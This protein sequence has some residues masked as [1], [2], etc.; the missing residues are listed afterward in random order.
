[1]IISLKGDN[2]LLR[3]PLSF[4]IIIAIVVVVIFIIVIFSPSQRGRRYLIMHF[5]FQSIGV[6]APQARVS[7]S[8]SEEQGRDGGPDLGRPWQNTAVFG[9]VSPSIA[10]EGQRSRVE[11]HFQQLAA[12]HCGTEGGEIPRGWGSTWLCPAAG[13]S[14]MPRY[15]AP[16]S[17]TAAELR[18]PCKPPSKWGSISPL[19]HHPL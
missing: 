16:C 17:L 15:S 6:Q 4:V 19:I 11:A 12:S 18:P 2:A 5:D 13:G 1:M 9:T 14:P 7:P 3:F 8:Q 10:G